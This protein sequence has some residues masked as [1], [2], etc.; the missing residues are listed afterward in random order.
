MVE[1][2]PGGRTEG[3]GIET[4]T[5]V[6]VR[7][8]QA[9]GVPACVGLLAP[10]ASGPELPQSGD[11][12]DRIVVVTVGESIGTWHAHF[13]G[14]P[15]LSNV[16]V[17]YVDV[18]TLVRS[19]T[20]EGSPQ[21]D[22]P[23]PAVSVSSPADL[24]SLGSALND[25]LS[26]HGTERIGLCLYSITDMLQFV[27]RE[28]LFKFL[29]TLSKR[30]GSTSAVAFYH[31]DA[32]TTTEELETLFSHCA[33]AVVTVGAQGTTVEPGRYGAGSDPI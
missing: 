29:F 9:A 21:D 20:A 13:D 14:E 15:S 12:F 7:S 26:T 22:V 31:V 5:T 3:G 19:T 1:S 24:A 28:F 23:T 8:P 6:L 18:R 25:L 32:E 16:P 4:A 33:E 2:S 30:L 17:D 27:D 10:E 11:S